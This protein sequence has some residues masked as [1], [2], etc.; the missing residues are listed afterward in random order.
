MFVFTA[1]MKLHPLVSQR[2]TVISQSL[3]LHESHTLCVNVSDLFR[4]VWMSSSDDCS[5]GYIELHTDE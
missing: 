1:H 5:E 2:A 3:D 4:S